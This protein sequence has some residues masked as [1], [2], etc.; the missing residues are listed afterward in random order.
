MLVPLGLWI[1]WEIFI[2][3]GMSGTRVRGVPD[4]LKTVASAQ[5]DF[6]TND[7]DGDGVKGY[8]RKDVAGLYALK[9]KGG[10]DAIKLIQVSLAGADAAAVEDVATYAERAPKA[11]F[12]FRALRFAGEGDPPDPRRFAVCAW[13]DSLGRSREMYLVTHEGVVYWKKIQAI[14][15]PAACPLDPLKDGWQ[16]AP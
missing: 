6:R 7:R 16:V 14:E 4:D 11:G 10:G 5:E 12:W 2:R 3:V 15:P 13:P 8:W 9:P 1:L